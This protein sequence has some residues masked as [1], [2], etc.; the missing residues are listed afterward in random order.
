MICADLGSVFFLSCLSLLIKKLLKMG[1]NSAKI[2]A[3]FICHDWLF[4]RFYVWVSWRSRLSMKYLLLQSLRFDGKRKL[5]NLTDLFNHSDLISAL[6]DLCYVCK[7]KRND[8]KTQ[9]DLIL[10]NNF[11]ISKQ[12][13]L[14]TENV[15]RS[16]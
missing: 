16:S 11:S 13:C 12:N 4:Y 6:P 8:I 5:W 10:Q 9:S 7:M 2:L 1:I 14:S 15:S 3:I